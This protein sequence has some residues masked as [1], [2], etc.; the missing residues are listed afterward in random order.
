[1]GKSKGASCQ[2]GSSAVELA[3]LGFLLFLSSASARVISVE[4]FYSPTC[5]YC[6]A[7]EGLLNLYIETYG[8]SI[9]RINV[10]EARGRE[11]LLQAYE[12]FGIDPS[13][14]AVPTTILDDKTF[15]LG[16]ISEE[17]LVE[18]LEECR[19][20]CPSTFVT[21]YETLPLRKA[22][23]AL[24]ALTLGLMDGTLN[25]CALAVILFLLAYL[26]GLG[27]RRVLL[28]GLTY[29]SMVFSVYLAFTFGLITAFELLAFL[30]PLS[31]FIGF[32]LILLGVLKLR[33]FLR[34]KEALLA[35]PDFARPWIERLAKMAT[36]PS[37]ALMGMFVSLVEIPC[38][39]GFP[40]AFAEVL[41]REALSWVEKLIYLVEYNLF[42]ISP[43][44][45]ISGVVQLGLARAERVEV[46]RRRLSRYMKLLAG[47]AFLLL[48][49]WILKGFP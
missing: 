49:I 28:Y 27:K 37:V 47:M 32:L 33:D 31:Y 19:L 22:P 16:E 30:T 40:I 17:R 6:E 25:P 5:P 29:S 38:A 45:I 36:L 13:M 9:E 15:I 2:K 10:L 44:L 26:I 48:G 24:L 23:I 11:R 42:F 21:P 7:M 41:R 8:L 18:L 34:P 3:L 39:G 12:R 43:L 46:L 20:T 4:F 1:L 35:V 14:A